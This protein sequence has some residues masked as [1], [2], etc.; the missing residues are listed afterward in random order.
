MPG[1]SEIPLSPSVLGLLSAQNNV[2][3]ERRFYH[4]RDFA[5]L[6]SE[7]GVRE[8]LHHGVMRKAAQGTGSISATGFVAV[9]LHALTAICASTSLCQRFLG[10]S[11]SFLLAACDVGLGALRTGVLD[12]QMARG[13]LRREILRGRCLGGL[14]TNLDCRLGRGTRLP[15]AGHRAPRQYCAAQ[16]QMQN[17]TH[18]SLPS[19]SRSVRLP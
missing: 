17:G 14:R 13:D 12:E 9:L 1:P 16:N 11:A 15:I 7:C 18:D 8:R 6:E 19:R 5:Y 4:P 2:K 3:A 10:A